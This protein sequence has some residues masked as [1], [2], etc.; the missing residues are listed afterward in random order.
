MLE[1]AEARC[2]MSMIF[3]T[4]YEPEGWYERINPDPDS[5]SPISEA[6][7]DIIIHNSFILPIDGKICMRE[8]YSVSSDIES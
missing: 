8:R 5:E 3:C 2:K 4:Q 7:M 6:I 1:I